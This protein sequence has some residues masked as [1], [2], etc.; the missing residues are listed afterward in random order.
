MPPRTAA[1]I[2][3][4]PTA[5]TIILKHGITSVFLFASPSWTFE[6]LSADLLEVLRDRYPEGLATSTEEDS[7]ITPIPAEDADVRVVFGT[8][9]DADDYTKGFK[10]F[11][12]GPKDT[13]GKK[14]LKKVSTLAFALLE[15]DQDE[16]EPVK[17]EVA[18]PTNDVEA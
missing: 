1:V 2:D 4:S 14:G 9:R 15:P 12:V 17:F 11:D 3:D 10:K 7:T 16:D 8:P 13:L 18:F 5:L 6:K